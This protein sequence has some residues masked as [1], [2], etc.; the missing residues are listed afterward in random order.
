MHAPHIGATALRVDAAGGATVPDGAR[1]VSGTAST[2]SARMTVTLVNRHL[3]ESAR[4]ALHGVGD[5]AQ[6][7]AQ[8]LTAASPR[9]QNSADDPDRVAPVPLAA[10]G[11]ARDGWQMDLP[12]HSL[13]TVQFR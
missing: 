8:L 5:L 1:A 6:P 13:A 11:N 4:I 2:D 12:P 9:D 10:S 7:D 3:T